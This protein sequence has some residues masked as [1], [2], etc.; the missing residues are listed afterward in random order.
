MRITIG[1]LLTFIGLT[2]NR[3]DAQLLVQ[4]GTSAQ[5]MAQA[6]TGANVQISNPVITGSDGSWGLFQS[7]VGN[8]QAQEGII[9]ATGLITNALGPNNTQSKST[10]FVGSNGSSKL[11]F[12]SGYATRDACKLEFD[13]IPAGDSLKFSFTFASEEYDEYACTNFNDVFGFF[14]SGPGIVGDPGLPGFHNIAVLPVTGEAITVNNVNHGN[15]NQPTSCP[16][17]NPQYHVQNPLSPNASIQYDGWTK[18]LVAIAIGLIPCETYHLELIIA[19]ASDRLWDSGVFIEEIQSNN[20]KV[21]LVTDG[22]NPIMYEGCNNG[23]VSFC[24]DSPVTQ[25]TIVSYY[26]HGNAQ[27]GIDYTLIDDPSPDFEHSITIP[28]GQLCSYLTINTIDDNIV[29]GTEYVDVIAVNPLCE[30]NILDSIRVPLRDSLE[31]YI[32][33]ETQICIG[34]Q[35][36]LQSDSGGTF[37]QWTPNT[38]TYN[39][40]STSPD[41]TFTPTQDVVVTLT[42]TIAACVAT[43]QVLIEVSD[44]ELQ[45]AITGVDCQ[46]VC[47]GVIDM[48]IL[49][50]IPP[51]NIDWNSGQFNTEDLSDVCNGTYNVRVL[52]AAGCFIEATVTVGFAP[53]IQITVSALTYAGGYNVSCNGASDGAITSSVVGGQPPYTTTY[54]AGPDNLPVGPVTVSVVDFN[55]CTAQTT[56]TLTQPPVL[57]LVVTNVNPILC[58]G[59]ETGSITVSGTGGSG[60]YPSYIWYLNGNQVNSGPTYDNAPGGTYQVVVEDANNCTVTIDV[61]LPEPAEELDGAIL[62][63]SNVACNGENTGAVSVT[64]VG[65]TILLGSDYGYSWADDGSTSPVRINLLAATYNCT[66][67]DDNGCSTLLTVIIIQPSPLVVDILIVNDIACEGQSCGNALAVGS[68]GAAGSYTYEWEAVPVG[69]NPAFPQFSPA[70]TFCEPGMYSITV[71]DV[72]D[73]KVDETIDITIIST[74][75]TATFDISDVLCAGD[76]TGAIDATIIGGIPPYDFNWIGGNCGQGPLSME[77]ISSVCAGL[78]CLTLTDS[79]GC[80]LDTCLTI[81]EPPALNYFFIMEPTLCADNCSGS[82][83]F[84]PAGGTPPYNYAWFGPVIPGTGDVFDLTDTLSMAEDM[85][86]LCKG[87]YLIVLSDSLGCS[88]ERTIT[89]TAPE[90]LLILTDSISDYNGYQVSCPEACDGWIYVTATGGT[91]VPADGYLYTWLEQALFGPG[92]AFQQ[93]V[94]PGFDDV[95]D[96]CASQDTVGYELIIID[97]NQCIQ[98]AF[99]IME[100]P[101]QITFD[102]DVTDVSCS[103]FTDGSI[104]VTVLG[105]VPPYTVTW[106]DTS[107]TVLATGFTLTNVGEGWYFASVIDL[108]GCTGMDSVFV[109]TPNPIIA[110][111]GTVDY[112]GFGQ[113]CYG[114]CE[115]TIFSPVTGGTQPYSYAWAEGDCSIAPFSNADAVLNGLCIGTYALTVTDAQGCFV[116]DTISLNQ[117]DTLMVN[118]IVMDITCEGFTDG[119][120]D[121]GLSGGVLPYSTDWTVL[122]DG[123]E[124]QTGLGVGEYSVVV[125]DLN[126]CMIFAEFEIEEPTELIVVATS[127]LMAGGFN[128]S[129]NGFCDGTINT[130]ISGGAGPY[131]ISWTGTAPPV[132]GGS[133]PSYTGVVCAGIYTVTVTDANGCIG[134]ATVTLTEAPPIAFVFNVLNPISCNG[135]CDGQLSAGVQGG[136][137]QFT[138]VWDDP[139][140]TVGP[141]T[142]ATLC[143]RVYCVTATSGNGCVVVGCLILSDPEILTLAA[144]VTNVSCGGDADGAIN[145]STSGGTLPYMYEWTGPNGYSSEQESISG[146]L[147]GSYCVTV[148]DEHDCSYVE[149]FD[150]T[151][152]APVEVM[153]LAS[154]YNGFGVTCNGACNG[155]IDLTA[156]GGQEPY[157]YFP[158][159]N[160]TDLCADPGFTTIFVTDNTGCEVSMDI[161]ITE[162]E[163][164]SVSLV[165]PFYDC[166]T[167]VSCTGGNTGVITSTVSGGTSPELTYYW[168]QTATGDTVAS[169]TGIPDID[170]L[171]AGDYELVIVDLNGCESNATINLTEPAVAF[172]VSLEPMIYP[173]G[174]NISCYNACDGS[175]ISTTEGE[176]GTSSLSW[177]M[178]DGSPLLAPVDLCA[179]EYTVVAMDEAQCIYTNFIELTQPDFISLSPV[180]TLSACFNLDTASIEL[181]ISGGSAP[182]SVTW[183][184]NLPGSIDQ[185]NLE[186]GVYTVI[187]QDGNDCEIEQEFEIVEPDTLE[188]SLFSPVLAFPDFNI[189]EYLGI[190]GSIDASIEGGSP[191]YSFVW[192]GEDGFSS[193]SQD[194]TDLIAGEYCLTVTDSLGCIWAECIELTEPFLLTLPNGMSPNGDGKNDGLYIQGLEGFETNTV[195]VYNRW[196]GQVFEQSNYRNSNLW[197]GEGKNGK[198]LPDGTYFVVLRVNDGEKELNGYL[199]IRR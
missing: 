119:S 143:E 125:T 111:L 163:I 51:F 27:N 54:S 73:C 48:T 181:N 114:D 156:I 12:I 158:A 29:E 128:V 178:D 30:E 152:P 109:G 195:Q 115:G 133:D 68:G 184:N 67:T 157:T 59:Q 108:N 135:D 40:S 55:G 97:D 6:I 168:I 155:T 89:V 24:L 194:I 7:N 37:F 177:F 188:G 140:M 50:G 64:G 76:S 154:D 42:S 153:V 146:L 98:N 112:N 49:D 90:D 170:G 191:S 149:C 63:Q 61:T 44:M 15:P 107:A 88:F 186:P 13:I 129:C 180:V 113:P 169:G 123:T 19:D 175:I 185:S 105:G 138:Y 122:P 148:T 56:I 150:V 171:F 26:L 79:N 45:F 137:G 132:D 36:S 32:S 93:G 77:D 11:S 176:C 20:V 167:N 187:I 22:G 198:L 16:P 96:L 81:Q 74:S 118:A 46:G 65:G 160:F 101:D 14:I 91:T 139:D 164:L 179:G 25:N 103:G 85:V 28:A 72:N 43:E 100:E 66:I 8:L 99:F 141:I 106:T 4:N 174:D 86:N 161:E 145:S 83:D 130:V 120:I 2:F 1:I 71:T 58:A 134:T 197:N 21:D 147:T 92:I 75:I 94:G 69:S 142:P 172:I 124:I 193:F 52:D 33:G 34:E 57:G 189:S 41:V 190:N 80:I 10:A 126:D 39:P 165:S 70:A 35:I 78:W 9:L 95:T 84:V 166:G 17:M 60:T 62:S 38:L 104:T 182:Y 127:P 23:T 5:Q 117:P 102:F 47:N 87:Q 18:D 82:I 192:S 199:E 159:Q 151:Q 110:P 131:S 183:D 53:P 173:S 136:V 31:L 162:P 144:I 3:L 121:L 196:G 116:C